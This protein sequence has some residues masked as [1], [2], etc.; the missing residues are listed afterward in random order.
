MQIAPD[1]E[2]NPARETIKDN[3]KSQVILAMGL[4]LSLIRDK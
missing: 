2:A 3:H 1:L 4:F